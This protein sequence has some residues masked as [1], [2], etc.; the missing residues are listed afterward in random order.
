MRIG[1]PE[2]PLIWFLY[3]DTP[4]CWLFHGL[5]AYRDYS[6][7]GKAPAC[8]GFEASASLQGVH[9]NPHLFGSF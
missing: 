9:A 7:R 4:Y 8:Y 3:V 1:A 5:D 6:S 2:H